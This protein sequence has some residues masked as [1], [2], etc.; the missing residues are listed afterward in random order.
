MDCYCWKRRNV[1]PMNCCCPRPA[2]VCR[3]C[4]KFSRHCDCKKPCGGVR[5][6]TKEV[7]KE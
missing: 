4:L 7:Q 2:K 3:E 1:L 5:P 6:R